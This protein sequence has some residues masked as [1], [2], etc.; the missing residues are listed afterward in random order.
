M[1]SLD[2]M[3]QT[4]RRIYESDR[5]FSY[6]AMRQT[7]RMVEKIMREMNL[8]QVETL[9][10]RSDGVTDH[11]GWLMPLA[12]DPKESTLSIV[13]KG[14]QE[15]Q[16]CSYREEPCSLGLYSKSADVTA[17]LALYTDADISGKIVLVTDHSPWIPEVMSFIRCGAL[18][19]VLSHIGFGAERAKQPAFSYLNSKSRKWLNYQLPFWEIPEHPF[20]FSI[21]PDEGRQLEAQLKQGSVT[22]HAKVDA[23]MTPGEIGV[24][25]GFLPGETSE[26]IVLTGHLFEQGANDNASGV[27]QMLAI[28]RELQ[29]QPRRRG[30]RLLFTHEAKSLQAYVNSLKTKPNFVAGLNVDMV[31]VSLD[32]V[33]GIGDSAP[34]F[35]TYATPLLKHCLEKHGFSASVGGITGI[36]ASLAEPYF[37][38]A[39]TYLEVLADANYHKSTD[40][41][42]RI[43][44]ETLATT[45]AITKEYVSFLVNAGLNEAAELAKLVRDY[46]CNTPFPAKATPAM[47]REIAVKRLDSIKNL[48]SAPEDQAKLAEVL[49][50]LYPKEVEETTMDDS[51]DAKLSFLYPIKNYRGFFSFEK[52]WLKDES[53]PEVAKLYQGWGAPAWIDDALMWA[54]GTR[55]AWEIWRR[56]RDSGSDVD[57]ELYRNTLQ[58]LQEENYVKVGCFEFPPRIYKKYNE[59]YP[60]TTT[61]EMAVD[62][63]KKLGLG[64][65]MKVVVHSAFRSLGNFEGGAKKFCTILQELVTGDGTLMM[66]AL[67]KYPNDGEAILFDPENTPART[68]ILSETFRTLPGV[69][70]SLDPTHSFAVWGKGKLDYVTT[71]HLYPSLHEKSPLGKL[72]TS[73]GY[74]LLISC[75]V[76]V[77]YMHIVETLVGAPCLGS[78]TEEYDG[79]VDGKKV[80]LRGW[81]WRDGNCRA[82]DPKKIY[83]HMRQNGTL[84]EAM[85]NRSHLMLFKLSDYREAYE[86][87]LRDPVNGCAGCPVRPRQVRQSVPSDWDFDRDALKETTAFTGGYTPLERK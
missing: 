78:R 59:L 48:V 63:L 55:S 10:Y 81:G 21:T 4:I 31:G 60:V 18:G 16:L 23:S 45:F 22:L 34:A 74:C 83:D 2:F 19:V 37:G 54:D 9:R 49:Q 1:E 15:K 38:T 41:P 20:A 12:W 77:T 52:Y 65:G 80:K 27:A 87:L 14:G 73:G 3:L 46:D 79:V 44:P 35:P 32:H 33:G 39:L 72:E 70:R 13:Q 71:H 5:F 53:H 50:S 8:T 57:L 69:V 85:L 86:K 30:I 24:V 43:D 26:E 68:G 29:K 75:A 67:S 40:T 61:P 47:R 7:W 64:A 58:F 66:P 76:A 84:R 36:D 56:L 51:S 82:F 42:D 28:V 62:A 25:T 17:E 11:A 6:S